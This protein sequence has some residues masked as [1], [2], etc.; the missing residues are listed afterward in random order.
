MK[1]TKLAVIPICWPDMAAPV[2]VTFFAPVALALAT[3]LAALVEVVEA[4]LLRPAARA[5]VRVRVRVSDVLRI[6][7]LIWAEASGDSSPVMPVRLRGTTYTLA[8]TYE[9]GYS[10]E[11]G[12]KPT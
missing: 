1:A 10:L 8:V 2:S 7:P 12:K 6:A 4:V 11:E 3:T 9:E 5:V